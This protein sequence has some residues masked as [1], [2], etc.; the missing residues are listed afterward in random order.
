MMEHAAQ[1]L[2]PGMLAGL[3]VVEFA[4][5]LGEYCGLLLQGLGAEVIKVEPPEG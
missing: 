3:R 5:E 4:D 1:S 2:K